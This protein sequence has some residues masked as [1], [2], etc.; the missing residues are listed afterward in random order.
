MRK[1]TTLRVGVKMLCNTSPGLG[2]H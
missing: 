2:V 1:S